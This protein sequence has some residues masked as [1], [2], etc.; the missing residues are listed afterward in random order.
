MACGQPP[1][2]PSI[3]HVSPI[4]AAAAAPATPAAEMDSGSTVENAPKPIAI[5]SGSA[6]RIVVESD[7]VYVLQKDGRLVS[8]KPP[9]AVVE[10]YRQPPG[11]VATGV[12][13]FDG[14]HAL[15]ADG[16]FGEMRMSGRIVPIDGPRD[17]RAVDFA[18][19]PSVMCV[20]DGAMTVQCQP[21]H[22]APL[23]RP[24][25]TNATKVRVGRRE[26]CAL[27]TGGELVCWPHGKSATVRMRAVE[28]FDLRDEVG[29]AVHRDGL[30][31]CWGE[32]P[33]LDIHDAAAVSVSG[34]HGGC[35]TRKSGELACWGWASRAQ[36]IPWLRGARTIEV[37][38]H[39]AC[40]ILPDERAVC[41][42][43]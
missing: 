30:L 27:R 39:V 5:A 11:E 28:D 29:C 8:W 19:M 42:T 25:T 22:D 15:Y 35:V 18:L 21:S 37:R 17:R 41:W 6:K 20:I 43:P 14:F 12:V 16:H 9:G 40:A 23:Q 7:Y 3:A 33:A 31:E 13:D 38:T 24:V 32:K 36:Q 1:A 10:E 4:D 26:S 34:A 2:A